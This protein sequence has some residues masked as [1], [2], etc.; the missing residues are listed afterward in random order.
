GVRAG[1]GGAGP[2]GRGC[3]GAGYVPTGGLAGRRLVE[4]GNRAPKSVLAAVTVATLVAAVVGPPR[5]RPVVWLAA[6]VFAGVP[7]QAVLG[8]ITVLTGLNPWTVMAHFLLS[9]VLIAVALVL[10]QRCRE[11]SD[12]PA[13]PEVRPAVAA[14]APP[15]R[16]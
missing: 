3:G 6:G 5:R 9:A 12:R 4:F 1:G 10:W 15:P 2:A 14:P 7:A 13:V 11:G 16:P 8:G